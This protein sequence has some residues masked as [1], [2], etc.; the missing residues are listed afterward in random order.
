MQ[1]KKQAQKMS[2][3]S[4]TRALT[5]KRN[6]AVLVALAAERRL[7]KAGH[8]I[9]TLSAERRSVTAKAI[10][11]MVMGSSFGKGGRVAGGAASSGGA[12]GGEAAGS[13][14]VSWSEV[15]STGSPCPGGHVLSVRV[16]VP[17]SAAAAER[18]SGP[19]GSEAP[20]LGAW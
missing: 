4:D 6:V 3:A 18:T 16:D 13:G 12:L 10:C 7:E 17:S 20:S 8:T 5:A 2:R 14:R 19:G 9:A 11:E 1:R 15:P